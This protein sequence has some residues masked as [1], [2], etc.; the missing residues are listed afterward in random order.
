MKQMNGYYSDRNGEGYKDLTFYSAMRNV[1]GRTEKFYSTT[2][3]SEL[4]KAGHQISW[5][6]NRWVIDGNEI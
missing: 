5:V 1:A 4:A 2:E 6:N 3:L